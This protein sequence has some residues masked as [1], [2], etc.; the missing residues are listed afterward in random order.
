MLQTP[1]KTLFPELQS[2]VAPVLVRSVVPLKVVTVKGRLGMEVVRL[3][4]KEEE[5]PCVKEPAPVRARFCAV[6][7]TWVNC[8]SDKVPAE[9]PAAPMP[10]VLV[11]DKLMV[12]VAPPPKKTPNPLVELTTILSL[13]MVPAEFWP[14]SIPALPVGAL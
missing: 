4:L 10:M 6:A 12:A 2:P 5:G 9:K 3:P 7:P 8:L 14:T 11:A 1:L 13:K